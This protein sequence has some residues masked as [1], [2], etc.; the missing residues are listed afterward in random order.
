MYY[1]VFLMDICYGYYMK[2]ILFLR[3]IYT[4]CDVSDGIPLR[5]LVNWSQIK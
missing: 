5:R 4:D 1:M 3:K 2:A